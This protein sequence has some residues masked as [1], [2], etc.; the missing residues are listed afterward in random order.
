MD[1]R[2]FLRRTA[3]AAGLFAAGS[4][5]GATP[6]AAVLRA[7]MVGPRATPGASHAARAAARA[8]SV[9]DHPARECPIDT[10]VVVMME[11][12]SFDHY[13]GWLPEAER[14]MENGRRLYGRGFTLAARNR[15]TYKN[16]A[17][18]QV[19]T[20]AVTE[21]T[22]GQT[23]RLC[24]YRI[25]GHTWFEGRR[26]RD[27][28]FL[29]RGTGNDRYAIAF[30]TAE[31]IP[32][33]ASLV[34]RYTTFDH[35]H[36][37]LLG[38]T[39]PNRQ[40]MHSAQSEGMKGDPGPLDIG[41]F[42]AR[43]IWDLLDRA[44]V[45][46]RYYYTDLPLLLLWGEQY[47]PRVSTIDDFRADAAAGTLPNVSFVDPG[48]IGVLRTDEH[49][50]GDID[51]GQRF[52]DVIVDALVHAPQWERTALVLTYDEWGG[53]FDTV[54]PPILADDRT[55]SN[56]ADNFGQ[57]GF[58]VPT[59]L[60]SPRALPNYVDHRVYDH[61]SILRFI[62]WR[63]LGAPPEGTSGRGWWLTKRDR[64]ANNIGR[65][66]HDGP[67]ELDPA[68]SDTQPLSVLPLSPACSLRP[69]D[70]RRNAGDPF[71]PS[72]HLTELTRSTYRGA[73]DRVWFNDVPR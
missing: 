46:A 18:E 10:V 62:E 71:V 40:Y 29:A 63:F 6:A 67:L 58:R 38:P 33:Y 3:Q 48:F 59:V 30:H 55:S 24:D 35:Y 25:P 5:L 14:Y 27:A 52:L 4:A 7:P 20:I 13:T 34:Q 11:N 1:R 2:D 44:N 64:N 73:Q 15:V 65:A 19:P 60:A 28:G 42:H 50:V 9:L 49:P 68:T 51:A 72:A 17:R 22:G 37:S 47:A 32:V 23:S 61:T 43:T 66:L 31:D 57:S 39:F 26:Q 12:R 16:P 36:S 45:P 56:D 54:K 69:V 70:E 21:L 8:D 53:F 41:I